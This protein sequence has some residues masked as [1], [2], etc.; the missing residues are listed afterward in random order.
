MTT[1]KK[2]LIAELKRDIQQDKKQL[3]KFKKDFADDPYHA[4]EWSLGAFAASARLRVSESAI[5]GLKACAIS[6]VLAWWTEEL[7]RKASCS[8]QSTSPSSNLIERYHLEAAAELV[9][10]LQYQAQAEDRAI[11]EAS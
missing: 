11:A 3:A 7:V 4:L 5:K 6:E 9:A 8:E 1:R 2:K 10:K